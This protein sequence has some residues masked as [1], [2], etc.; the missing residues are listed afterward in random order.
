MI[1]IAMVGAYSG[2]YTDKDGIK[3]YTI[4][5]VVL[6]EDFKRNKMQGIHINNRIAYKYWNDTGYFEIKENKISPNDKKILD[7]L[8]VADVITFNYSIEETDSSALLINDDNIITNIEKYNAPNALEKIT[9][10]AF[11]KIVRYLFTY[12]K[13]YSLCDVDNLL[14]SM[15]AKKLSADTIA[16]YMLCRN[17]HSDDYIDMDDINKYTEKFFTGNV[18]MAMAQLI[19]TGYLLEDPIYELIDGETLPSYLNQI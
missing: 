3:T 7:N 15:F 13:P 18:E 2:N 19:E 11:S 14:N 8:N 9:S 16:L 4:E 6:H 5:P 12:K 1:D 10:L 17:K